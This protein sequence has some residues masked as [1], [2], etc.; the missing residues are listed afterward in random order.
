MSVATAKVKEKKQ[1]CT[2]V[3][4][5]QPHNEIKKFFM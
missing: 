5:P 4:I 3:I 2:E 1:L